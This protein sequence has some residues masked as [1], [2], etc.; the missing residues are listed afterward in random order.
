MEQDK[1][2]VTLPVYKVSLI[3]VDFTI[4]PRFRTLESPTRACKRTSAAER[5][6]TPF[7]KPSSLGLGLAFR[8][9]TN[10]LI[11]EFKGGASANIIL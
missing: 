1:L 10:I 2:V 9:L 6:E 3:E 7:G 5:L 11:C 8:F 4:L